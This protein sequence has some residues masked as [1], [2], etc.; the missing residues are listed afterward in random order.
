MDPGQV[1]A[2]FEYDVF[3]SYNSADKVA[4]EIIASRLREE[5]GFDLF[6]DR[7]NLIPGTPWQEGIE[8]ALAQSKTVAVFVGPSGVSPWHNEEMRAALDQAV[9]TRDTG[10]VIPVL[11]PGAREEP[12]S[13]FLARRVR[14][15]FRS[16]L[17]D[18]DAFRRLVAGIDGILPGPCHIPSGEESDPYPPAKSEGTL[19]PASQ[20][21]LPALREQALHM[22]ASLAALESAIPGEPFSDE[23]LDLL[24]ERCI[25]PNAERGQI[26]LL[27]GQPGS[28]KTLF[29]SLLC[30]KLQDQA[31]AVGVRPEY[32]TDHEA[33]S[34]RIEELLT[35][36][37][38]LG[39]A[40]LLLDSLDKLAATGSRGILPWL[41]LLH[42]LKVQPNVVVVA[43]CRPF[44]AHH[45]FP[46]ND[47]RWTHTV[48]LGLPSVEWVSRRLE[49][50]A[51]IK[52]EDLPS[53]LLTFL[54]VPLHLEVALQI[55]GRG[56]TF[57]DITTLQ[58]L[59]G[60]LLERMSISR[61]QQQKLSALAGAMVHERQVRL[62]R[63]ALPEEV[64]IDTLGQ[65]GLVE[66]DAQSVWFRHQTLRDYLLAWQVAEGGRPLVDFLEEF[67]QGLAIRPVMWHL[68]H[69][70]RGS[71]QRL[72]R[73]LE[74]LFFGTGRVRTHIKAG[75]LAILASWSDPSPQE[76]GFLVHLLRDAPD[77]AQ[78][79]EQFFEHNPHCTWF[80]LLR[81]RYLVLALEGTFG[82]VGRFQSARFLAKVAT[83]YP[84]QVLEIAVP[85]LRRQNASEWS[86]MFVW[87][88]KALEDVNL[89][90]EAQTDYANLLAAVIERG[91]IQ[92]GLQ[93]A[94][95]CGQL[96]PID[97]KRALRLYF[98]ALN[99]AQAVADGISEGDHPGD[100]FQSVLPHLSER[101]PLTVLRESAS[102]LETTFRS[103]WTEVQSH[104][105]VIF[106][107]PCEWL[108]GQPYSVMGPYYGPEV[109]LGWFQCELRVLAQS[110]PQQARH[111]IDY[112]CDSQWQTLQHVG[113]LAMLNTPEWYID[114]LFRR[115][116][117][118]IEK[119]RDGEQELLPRI[120]RQAFT[121]FS[122]EQRDALIAGILSKESDDDLITYHLVYAPLSQIPVDVLPEDA[123]AKLKDMAKQFGPYDYRPVV[124]E[125]GLLRGESPV[126]A[127]EL[128]QL[129]PEELYDLLVA[130]RNL[131]G[132]WNSSGTT[133]SGGTVEL[134]R[135]TTGVVLRALPQY[136]RMLLRLAEDPAN[137]TYFE[138]LLS[139]IKPSA[140]NI[141][142]LI[143]L[144]EKLHRIT[145]V[146]S[147]LPDALAK[148]VE[149]L[150][151]EQWSR[152]E[153]LCL[154]LTSGDPDTRRRMCPVLIQAAGRFWNDNLYTA[155][156]HLA[157][158][159]VI[160]VRSSFLHCLPHLV[161]ARGWQVSV[162]LFRLAFDPNQPDL[163]MPAARFLGYVPR[164]H[165][166]DVRP[167]W[168]QMRYHS[169]DLIAH[170]AA[171][172]TAIYALRGL[173]PVEEIESLLLADYSPAQKQGAFGIICGWVREPDFCEKG[174][175]V[176]GTVLAKGGDELVGQMRNA[177]RNFRP[178]DLARVKPFT[179]KVVADPRRG[180]IMHSVLDYLGRSAAVHPR[181][182]FELLEQILEL[183]DDE[184]TWGLHN[185]A[186]RSGSPWIILTPI[187]DGIYPDLEERALDVFDRLVEMDWRGGDAY[188]RDVEKL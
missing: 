25:H 60:R 62:P 181:L 11:L 44:E 41:R 31:F 148:A 124:H 96:A 163:A 40:V 88:A 3:L 142:W 51:G 162:N 82:T 171:I 137:A 115:A 81:E 38:A 46:L 73:E 72:I 144:V 90:I 149:L 136:Q 108:Y 94:L 70:L 154:D 104:K 24:A 105:W 177:F 79:Q 56:G 169:V 129:A 63:Y 93:V 65:T 117:L 186:R 188:L 180:T 165:F 17:D 27:T 71:T 103:D 172:L 112:L 157:Q 37:L 158:D 178:V 156:E 187:L 36:A 64:S 134:A 140:D 119:G 95:H 34:I 122:N 114:R 26:V 19:S 75:L 59:Y 43:A 107:S 139:A 159:R 32:L 185:H 13:R 109:F 52:T 150:T 138:V 47:Q 128:R 33:M 78:W 175:C 23:Q 168:E 12:V 29:L 118:A 5:A 147:S 30:R 167:L 21:P 86:G 85:F 67:G 20:L 16:G 100:H 87:I 121:C 39:P 166:D 92:G 10:R 155:L 2:M 61:E 131:Q 182:A 42:R 141:D 145:P 80:A 15:D 50:H 125:T 176:L 123:Q 146:P 35:Q 49:E 161:E 164:L 183:P 113:F 6:L 58:G 91:F 89:P 130:N 101:E 173:I 66:L 153:P 116:V 83:S 1:S 53:N 84:A 102:F 133:L 4:V 28:G 184:S 9:R 126:P 7:W 98:D 127:E 106:D 14:V 160:S 48:E 69:M 174:L 18:D 179:R 22:S 152:L 120:L 8:E 151:A 110:H 54:S 170:R 68:L 111:V 97:P 57:S 45:T 99:A 132:G 135:V 143:E 77:R 55:A 74:T 76:A